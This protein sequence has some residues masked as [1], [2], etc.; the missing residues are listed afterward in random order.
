MVL[1]DSYG[2]STDFNPS[3]STP[4]PVFQ[5]LGIGGVSVVA[6]S[7]DAGPY[8]T[9][10]GSCD[11]FYTA[12][13]SI[14]PFVTSVGGMEFNDLGTATTISGVPLCSGYTL[15]Y[16]ASNYDIIGAGVE[17]TVNCYSDVS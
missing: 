3:Y 1:S 13:P 7:G 15:D 17:T 11:S 8:N 10:T 12:Y 2:Y 9:E 5:L 4:D 16:L 14:S 6:A